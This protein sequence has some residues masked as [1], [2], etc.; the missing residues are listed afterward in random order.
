MARQQLNLRPTERNDLSPHHLSTPH[1]LCL[2]Y[3]KEERIV[4]AD[5]MNHSIK[6]FDTAGKFQYQFQNSGPDRTYLCCPR[7]VAVIGEG[8]S[9]CVVV[10]DRT[11]QIRSRLQIFKMNGYL[12]R[13]IDMEYIEIV[14][15][16][17]VT[18][19]GLIV[20]A[21]SVVPAVCTLSGRGELLR[22]FDCSDEMKEPSD[23]A[24]TDNLFYVSD[25]KGHCIVEFHP[26]G[27]F[28]RR[29][30]RDSSIS[31]P[32]GI[33]ISHR[34]YLLVADSHGNRVHITVFRPDGTQIG[35]FE[36]SD[37]EVSRCCGLKI[38]A[39]GYLVTLAKTD[40]RGLI[41]DRLYI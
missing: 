19:S 35:A 21:D 15:G 18:P 8:D 3:G 17:A 4:L 14:A 1:G 26:Y 2:S 38:T 13:S 12:W 39:E 36:Y 24:V 25:F 30:G 7:K 34:G 32:N 28:L 11:S 16:L 23:I 22:W 29:I 31:F 33:D 27:Q 6:F 37:L 41:F 5:T 9:S 20:A 10:C 40:S